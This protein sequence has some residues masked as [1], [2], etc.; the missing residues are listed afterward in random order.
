MTDEKVSRRDFLQLGLRGAVVL[1]AGGG[2]AALARA[3]VTTVWQID[4]DK[5][6]QCAGLPEARCATAC[7]KTPSAVKCVH[8]HDVCGYCKLCTGFFLPQPNDLNTAAENQ[9]CPTGA[10]KRTFIEDPY[11]EYVIDRDLCIGCAKCVKGC[12][13]FGN[14]SLF[15][16]IIHDRDHCTECNECAIAVACPAQAI[17]RVPATA[18]YLLKSSAE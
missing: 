1:A 4:P 9:Q 15:L 18:P 2:L 16:Q 10:I 17:V 3:H 8:A 5:C 6:T 11:Y 7:V 12:T 13:D 14:G